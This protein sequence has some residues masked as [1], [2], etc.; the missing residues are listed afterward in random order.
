HLC[1][2]PDSILHHILFFLDTKFVVQ[3]CVLSKQWE[4]AWKHVH[5][6]NLSLYF[7][8]CSRYETFVDNFLSFRHPRYA[9]SHGAQHFNLQP[10]VE[11]IPNIPLLNLFDSTP[12]TVRTLKLVFFH[13]DC[14]PVLEW[15]LADSLADSISLARCSLTSLAHFLLKKHL[16]CDEFFIVGVVGVLVDERQLLEEDS[17]FDS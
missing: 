17:F 2:F 6:L 7:D 15:N 13:F 9:V 8:E 3:T 16:L 12:D 1:N 5:A 14:R 10:S 4:S 11:L